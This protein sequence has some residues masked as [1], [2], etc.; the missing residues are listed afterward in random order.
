MTPL[1]QFSLTHVILLSSLVL[2]WLP[3]LPM[4]VELLTENCNKIML[5]LLSVVGRPTYATEVTIVLL[6]VASLVSV[7]LS[8]LL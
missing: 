1:K 6:N 2:S 5:E 4:L 7:K 8:V 3:H